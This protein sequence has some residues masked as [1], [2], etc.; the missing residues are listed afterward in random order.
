[1]KIEYNNNNKY[2]NNNGNKLKMKNN[3]NLKANNNH[4]QKNINYVLRERERV[5]EKNSSTMT[6]ITDYQ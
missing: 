5:I 1:M 6:A 4:K 3:N 2:N